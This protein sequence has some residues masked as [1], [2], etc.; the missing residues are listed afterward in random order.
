MH[1]GELKIRGDRKDGVLDHLVG[2]KHYQ[3]DIIVE[4]DEDK[5]DN[6]IRYPDGRIYVGEIDKARF[7]P[8]GFGKVTFPNESVYEGEW[9]D[10]E[11]HGHGVFRWKDGSAYE[12][13]YK[14]GKKH[15]KGTFYFTNGNRYEGYWDKGHQDGKGIVF[16]KDGS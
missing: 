1:K 2:S 4:V 8:H 5:K 16:S 12:G 15:G 13:E 6:R 10:S 3:G 9:K 14:H 11:M 7:G